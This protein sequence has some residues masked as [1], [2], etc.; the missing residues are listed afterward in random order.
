[1]TLLERALA[2]T[3]AAARWSSSATRSRLA[4]GDLDP[5]A[6]PP[7]GGPAAGLL[8]GV[9]A[10]PATRRLVAVLAVDMPHVTAATLA[11]LVAALGD[12]ADGA[13]LVDEGGRRQPLC[14]VYRRSALQRVR[15]APADE[16]GLPVR[17]LLGALRLVEVAARRPARPA[18]STPGRTSGALARTGRDP[19]VGL[20]PRRRRRTTLGGWSCTSGRRAHGRARPRGRGRRGAGPRRRA[21]G[22]AQ[23][24]AAG[25]ADDDVPAGVRRGASPA[26]ARGRRAARRP[27]RRARRRSGRARRTRRRGSRRSRGRR[28]SGRRRSI[29]LRPPYCGS[30]RAVIATEP[31]GPDVLRSRSDPTR[32]RARRGRPRRRGVRRQPGGPAAA[33]GALPTAARRE[34]RPRARVQRDGP[35]GRR[36]RRAL[37]G[38]RRGVRAA[39]RRGVRRA[40]ARARRAAHGGPCRG[41]PRHRGGAARGGLHGLV[42]RL[43]GRRPPAR[44]RR[45]SSTAAPAGSAPSPSSSP[46]PSAPP[47]RR[48]PGRQEKLEVCRSLGADVRSTTASED[49]VEVVQGRRPAAG[50]RR[51]L[52]NMGAAYL[53]RN[54]DVLATS[55]RLVVIGMQGGSRRRARPRRAHAQARARSSRRRCGPDR[56]RRRRRSAPRSRSTCGRSS[57]TGRCGPSSTTGSRSPRSPGR[58]ARWRRAATSGRCSS[59]SEPSA[60][61]VGTARL[62]SGA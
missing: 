45:C 28:P 25:G 18:T 1:M 20:L 40:G 38:R 35:R 57:P 48:P 42:E 5:R 52:D 23:R 6:D 30:M 26:A 31:G 14:G 32:A 47:S 49:F 11:R 24:G 36:G 15:P 37:A 10:L 55:G 13:L 44:A 53:S 29:P 27:D 17:R 62:P 60:W 58:T 4:A 46:S 12:D 56:R 16:H 2:A 21:R 19:P 59:P 51:V 34:R 50:R 9:D 3:A 8:A 39:R 61:A 41:R 43:H 33:A 22:G 7:G 54:L